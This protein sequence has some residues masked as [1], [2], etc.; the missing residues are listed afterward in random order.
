M[1]ERKPYRWAP[2]AKSGGDRLRRSSGTPPGDSNRE[3]AMDVLQTGLG[4]AAAPLAHLSG[5]AEWRQ[6]P[7]RGAR[8]VGVV[9][10]VTVSA[11]TVLYTASHV[12]RRR[13]Q[14][15]PAKALGLAGGVLALV[16]GYFG[17]HLSHVRGVAVGEQ[18]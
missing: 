18:T 12:A 2:H 17:G 5:I 9:H 7:D 3:P 8:R 14:Q 1:T 13:Q 11:A 6:A 10:G 4:L 16:D 15:P